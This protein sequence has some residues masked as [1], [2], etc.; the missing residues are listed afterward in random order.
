MVTPKS[1]PSLLVV[2]LAAPVCKPAANI[3]IY[4]WKAQSAISLMPW[5]EAQVAITSED[6]PTRRLPMPN[7]DKHA[8]PA[9]GD[10]K[11][12]VSS[13]TLRPLIFNHVAVCYQLV[14]DSQFDRSSRSNGY[15]LCLLLL[16]VRRRRR[17]KNNINSD[18]APTGGFSDATSNPTDIQELD[19]NRRTELDSLMR[20]EADGQA[21]RSPRVQEMR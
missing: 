11:E 14:R 3:L 16:F 10:L 13:N 4:A 7:V 12:V 5:A 21:G 20:L 1:G 15:Q 19:A 18:K 9:P 17:R 8:A 6:A 2:I